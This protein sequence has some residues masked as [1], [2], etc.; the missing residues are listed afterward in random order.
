MMTRNGVWL[1][2]GLCFV[3]AC[4]TVEVKAEFPQPTVPVQDLAVVSQGLTEFK[5]KFTGKLSA[6]EPVTIEKA[7][8]ELVVDEKVVKKGEA[9]INVQVAANT[10]TDFTIEQSSVYAASADA[11][12][13]MDARGGSL[14]CA[15]RGKLLVKSAGRT[16]EVPFARSHD[17]RV[18]RLPHTKFQELEAG[19]Y[20]EDEMG[21][22]FHIG[23][24]NPNPFE[25][26]VTA[27]KYTILIAD[28]QV[29]ESE[30]GKGEKVSPSSTGV[31]DIEAKI[32]AETHPDIK[33]LIK[34]RT[35]PYVIKGEL[36][37]ELF[38]EAFEFK[39][40]IN[41]PAAK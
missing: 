4:K 18:P 40:V 7:I 10:P 3:A 27:I 15:L 26:K 24:N 9:A 37:A 31:F 21:V 35:L 12:K 30:I 28:K 23:V 25:V 39:G 36:I 41:L 34:A 20:S 13:A 33:K 38:S 22:T 29:A 11:L 32:T 17:V 16:D 19:R 14:L 5:L 6:A 2:A 8:Y 1:V